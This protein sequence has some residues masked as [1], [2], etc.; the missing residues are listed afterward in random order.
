MM[1][2]SIVGLIGVIECTVGTK[3]VP[4]VTRLALI[5]FLSVPTS[6]ERNERPARTTKSNL[7]NHPFFLRHPVVAVLKF[8]H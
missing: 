3:N 4:I 2:V 8:Q 5:F 6:Y 1:F 7:A